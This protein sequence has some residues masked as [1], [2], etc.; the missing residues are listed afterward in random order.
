MTIILNNGQAVT[1]EAQCNGLTSVSNSFSNA[2]PQAIFRE[3]AAVS[4]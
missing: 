1:T 3:S 2:V 4:G